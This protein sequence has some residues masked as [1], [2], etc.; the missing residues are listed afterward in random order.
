MS[1][2]QSLFDSL[3]TTWALLVLI[4]AIGVGVV[5]LRGL[6]RFAW[7]TFM[8]GAFGLALLGALY[9]LINYTSIL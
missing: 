9:Y 2:I 6:I 3:P 1:W 7:R 8:F 5:I 4:G